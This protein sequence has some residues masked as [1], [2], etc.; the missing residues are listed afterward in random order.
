MQAGALLGIV[1]FRLG[2]IIAMMTAAEVK[3]G[4]TFGIVHLHAGVILAAM[5]VV[6]VTILAM[7]TATEVK[8]GSPLGIVHLLAGVIIATLTVVKVKVLADMP[9]LDG[10]APVATVIMA[11]VTALGDVVHRHLYHGLDSEMMPMVEVIVAKALSATAGVNLTGTAATVT[12][13]ARI[14]IVNSVVMTRL[15]VDA[16]DMDA[17]SNATEAESL[18]G[19][20]VECANTMVLMDPNANICE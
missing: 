3:V 9:H 6:E 19:F 8:E 7:M 12:T 14:A 11:K 2:T 10:G 13:A 5:T 4:T 15:T 16:R 1:Q 18:T 20:V 17:I